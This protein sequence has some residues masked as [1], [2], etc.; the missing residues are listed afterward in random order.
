[1]KTKLTPGNLGGDTRST[2]HTDDLPKKKFTSDGSLNLRFDLQ[3]ER[4]CI[5]TKSPYPGDE[6]FAVPNAHE[7]RFD[8]PP[9][10]LDVRAQ[11]KRVVGIPRLE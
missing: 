11:N 9:L 1:M 3:T 7:E 5:M 2:L 6:R 10:N 8:L 4:E